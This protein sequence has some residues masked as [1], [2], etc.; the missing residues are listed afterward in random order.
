MVLVTEHK[1]RVPLHEKKRTGQHHAQGK[2]Y[3]KTYWPYLPLL[4]IVAGGLLLN[5]AWA[6][7][8]KVLGYAVNVSSTALLQETNVQ[9]SNDHEATLTLS[10]ALANAA[11]NK[12][13]DMV[14]QDYWAHVSPSG[15][16]PW[17]FI[18]AAGYNYALAGENLAYGFGTSDAVI[19]AWMHSAEHRANILNGQ[20]QNV[21]FGIANA[22]NFQGK[23]TET[24]VVAM[25]GEPAGASAA[26]ANSQQAVLGAQTTEAVTRL[27]LF[28]F[29]Q[30]PWIFGLIAALAGAAA[31]VLIVRHALMWRRALVRSEA[32][33]MRHR[34]FDVVLVLTAI[35]GFVVTRAAGTIG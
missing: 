12:A 27:D 15:E 25:Y 26:T 18:T 34:L 5:A 19:N 30:N 23:G 31:G 21:G 1:R 29:A 7:Q 32:F 4:L 10:P 2:H 35:V 17:Q 3:G 8:G 16:Q 14:K 20:Y 24:V 28:G 33:V 13:D 22:A 6:R 11:Q 9:R